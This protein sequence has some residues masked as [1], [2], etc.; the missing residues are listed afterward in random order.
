MPAAVAVRA[1][2]QD[3]ASVGALRDVGGGFVPLRFFSGAGFAASGVA[4]TFKHK[5]LIAWSIVPMLVQV[6]LFGGLLWG[7]LWLLDGGLHA[8]GPEPGHW[9]SF[10]GGVARVIGV[11]AVVV[12][13]VLLSLMLG[14]IVCDPFYD[15]LSEATEAILLGRPL[16]KRRTVAGVAGGIVKEIL[17]LPW[18]L[19][20]YAIVA[21]PLWLLSLTGVGAVIAVP[22]TLLWTWMFVA[23][24]GMSRSLARHAVPKRR[25]FLIIFSRPVVALGFGA[26]GWLMSHLPLTYPFLVVGGTRLHLA[27]AAWDR[28]DSDLSDADKVALRAPAKAAAPG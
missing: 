25:R 16:S 24:S 9:Y 7:G 18:R 19:V 17:G 6:G 20:M 2:F 28:L 22:L 27:L 3:G 13:S 5:R 4:F 26:A 10:V 12:T 21:G 11:A 14:S 8:I 1:G 23:L 15:V